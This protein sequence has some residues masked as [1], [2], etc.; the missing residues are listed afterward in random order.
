MSLYAQSLGGIY[1]TMVAAVD[2]RVNVAA[3]NVPAARSSRSPGCRRRSAQRSARWATA[4]RRCSMAAWTA[5]PS[6][7]LWGQPVTKPAG[8]SGDPGSV[9]GN[10]LNRPGSPETFAPLLRRD[11]LSDVGKKKFIYQFAFGD[12]TVPNPTSS[13]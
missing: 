8:R 10:W 1:G 9:T 6:P 7:P 5:S 11:P 4:A 12:E 13:T 3:L 2:D